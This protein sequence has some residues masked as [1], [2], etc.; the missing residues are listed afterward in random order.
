F[1][2]IR[3]NTI[4][5]ERLFHLPRVDPEFCHP[6]AHDSLCQAQDSCSFS[7]V[8]VAAFQCIADHLPFQ[9]DQHILQGAF[10]FL[11]GGV[12]AF[13]QIR[14]QVMS[15]DDAVC[16]EN[17][18]PFDTVFKLPYISRP[19]IVHEHV[20][21]RDGDTHNLLVQFPGVFIDEIIGQ[22][23]DVRLS[24]PQGWNDDREDV[25]PIIE[26]Y[27]KLSFLYQ[28]LQIPICCGDNPDVH[29]YT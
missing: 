9:G 24:L 2:G 13:L 16:T 1:V 21:C 12:I 15:S 26:I 20:C 23:D 14:R 27:P 6:E 3:L 4:Y 29:L 8:T 17:D 10:R 5:Q 7:H 25:Q 11:D 19:M 28:C 18:G 22:Q